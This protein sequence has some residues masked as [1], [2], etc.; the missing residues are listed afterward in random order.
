[1]DITYQELL[2]RT[3]DYWKALFEVDGRP[4]TIGISN[5]LIQEWNIQ[6]SEKSVAL[7]LKQ[8]GSLKIM[9]M[10]SM[11]QVKDYMFTAR[12]FSANGAPKSVGELD[13]FLKKEIFEAEEDKSRIGFKSV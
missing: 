6:Q 5:T 1:M 11:G 3:G 2:P 12:E 8:F 7:F 9:L 13:D 10:V 4:V